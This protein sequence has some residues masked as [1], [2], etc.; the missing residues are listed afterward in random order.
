MPRYTEKIEQH[1]LP[2]IALRGAVAFPGVSLSFELTDELCIHA[3]EAAFATDSPVLVCTVQKPE[4]ER[5]SASIL[6]RVGTVSRI[7]QSVKTPDGGMRII[8]EGY[9]RATIV[10]FRSF[11]DYLCA[12]AISKVLT[13]TEEDNVRSEAYC[14]AILSE[15]ER[16][17][18]LLPSVSDDVLTAARSIK[19]PAL[20]ADFVAA[21]ILV[22]YPDKQQ[23]LECFDPVRRIELLVALLREECELLECELD[24]HKRVRANL[25]QN[26]KEY[27][28]REQVRVIQDELGDLG[29]ADE[30]YERI[31]A[32]KMP[33]DVREKLLKENDR[34]AKTPFGSSEATVIRAYLDTCLDIPWS[35]ETKDRIDIKAAERILNAD[36]DGLEK[37]KERILEYLAVKQLNP[38]LGN[39][40][41]C[42][43]GPPGV[44][45]TSVGSSI[46]K[47]MKRKYV[48]VS[49]G[50]VRDEADIRGHRKTYIGAMPGRIINALIQ[51]KVRNPLI[52]L[53][54]IDKVT[55][56]AHGDPASALLEVLDAE[57]N[58][59]FR[60]HFVELPFDLSDC[61]FIAT[62]NTLDTIPRPLLDRMEVIELKTYT[63]TE[64]LSIAKHHLIPKQI[65]RHGMTRRMLTITDSAVTELI[66]YYTREA[67]VRNLERSIADLCRKA[68]KKFVEDAELKRL[69]ITDADVSEYL[70]VR[71]LR[72]EHI[73]EE[74]E[75]G[76]VNGLAYTAAGG[77]MLR[78]EVAVLDGTGKIELTGSLGDVMK[79]SARIA[80]SYV[81]SIAAE[82]GI[83]SDFYEKKDIHIH[84]PEGAVPK[85][86]PSAGVTI[87]TALVSALTGRKVRRD[88][89]MT[90]EISLRGSVLAIGGLKEKTMA[91]YSAGVTT[92]L[93]PQDNM[94]NVEEIDPAA[95]EALTF[96]PCKKV[97][98]V[99]AYALC[100]AEERAKATPA[101]AKEEEASFAEVI[102][103]HTT[104]TH[105]ISLGR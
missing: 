35:D 88:I 73:A 29:D 61:L 26:Q 83:P 89:A 31:L 12:D 38:T 52:L 69:R 87:V 63:K 41:L 2:V 39:Q 7:K 56:D 104:H 36:H 49:L 58:K 3:A 43:V 59:A 76:V 60:D 48:R 24:I 94:Q 33:D 86:G 18:G 6:Y 92:V 10:D 79:E 8:T 78:V 70:G 17:V 90:G 21:N 97:S 9:A 5:L 57:Q 100:P 82:Y 50:G 66:D 13:M 62:A 99:L 65:K 80:V 20:L 68:A 28:L 81:R 40:I 53:D 105:S 37:V 55:R 95:K 67:G 42:L 77:D 15:T 47:A 71:K 93:L 85:D 1:S 19:N 72:P 96:L 74:D 64:K 11:A 34:M 32:T 4:E 16:L 25:N 103:P 101:I 22:K 30:Y 102:P 84:F 46:A 54:E 51:A 27:Y 45:K 44:G 23:I 91:A 98:E 14:R 75:V